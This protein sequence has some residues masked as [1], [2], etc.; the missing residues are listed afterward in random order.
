MKNSSKPIPWRGVLAVIGCAL[1][2]IVLGAMLTFGNIMPYMASYMRSNEG[3]E[4]ITYRWYKI[5]L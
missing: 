1:V 5:K 3:F 4:D 2:N